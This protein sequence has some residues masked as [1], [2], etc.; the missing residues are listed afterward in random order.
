MKRILGLDLGTNSIG[1]A[2]IQQDFE[3]HEGIINDLGV[4]IIPMD[5]AELSDYESGN[6]ISKT[7]ERTRLRGARRIRERSLLRRERLHRVLNI[8]GYLPSHYKDSIDFEHHPGKFHE[9][10]EPK[11]AYCK[12]KANQFE[13]LFKDSFFEM[14]EDFKQYQPSLVE[15]GK[16]I[17]YDWTIYFLRKKA[18]VH[19]LSKEELA[20]VILNFNQKRGYYQLRGDE[21]EEDET[22]IVEYHSLKV[23]KVEADSAKKPTG[24]IWYNC[25]LENG[26]IYRRS[27]KEP[28]EWEGKIKEF[29]VTTEL[30]N[31]GVIKKDKDGNVK[32]S[33]RVPKEDDWTLVKKKTELDIENSGKTI[34]QYIYDCILLKPDQK[35][36]GKLIRTIERK[37]YRE[38]LRKIL[39]KQKEFHLEFN[40]KTILDECIDNLYPNNEAHARSLKQRNLQNLLIEDIIFYQRPLK[41]KKSDVANCKFEQY[42]Y[43]DQNGSEIIVPAKCIAKSHPLYQEFRLWKF[44]QS[45]RIYHR[46]VELNGKLIADLDITD[47]ILNSESA[48]CELFNWLNLK[49]S[50]SQKELLKFYQLKEESYR[51][52]YVED[53]IY[54]CNETKSL[55]ISRLDRC[56]ND[57]GNFLTP[58]IEMHLWHLLFSIND[59]Q[60]LRK[61]LGSFAVKHN[62]PDSFIKEFEK[63]PPF[64]NEYG[65]YSFKALRKILP[66]MKTGEYWSQDNFEQRTIERISKIVNG[67]FD[68]N[69]NTRVREKCINLKNLYDFKFIP[70][71]L[72]SYVV[73]NRFTEDGDNVK[74]NSPQDIRDY[75]K[76][77]FKQHSL[78]NPVVE[79]VVTETLRVVADLWDYHGN[80]APKYFDEIHIELG[81]D[82]KNPVALRQKMTNQISDNENTNLRLK[83]LLLELLNDSNYE[84]IRPNS[85]SQLD[86]LKIYEEGALSSAIEIND[87]IIKIS[88]NCTPTKSELIKYKLWLEQK[89]RSP[90]TG[91]IIPLSKLFTTA[92]QIEHIIPQARF[93]DDSFSN[94]VICEAEVN[95][96]KGKQLAF[97]YIVNNGGKIIQ[98]SYGKTVTILRTE[99][100]KDFIRQYY[101]SAITNQKKKKLLMEDIPDSFIQRQLNDTRYISKLVRNLLSR[102]VREENEIEAI[103]K[104]IVTVN[105]SITDRLKTDWGLKS[106][107]NEIVRPRFE[108]LNYLSGTDNYGRWINKDGKNVFQTNVPLI[109]Q[110]GFSKKRIDHRHH[111]LDA[112]VIA[113]ATRN[114]INYLNNTAAKSEV[115][116]FE[117]RSL[118]CNK[119]YSVDHEVYNWVFKKPWESIT[120]DVYNEL[121]SIIVSFKQN[122]RIINR[123]VN[124][125]VRWITENEVRKQLI[126]QT[127]GDNW[128]VRKPLHK[129]T[130]YGR[131]NLQMIK[132][133]SIAEALKNYKNITDNGLKAYIKT[134]VKEGISLQTIASD[135]KSQN[136]VY[137]D[138]DFKKV[139]IYYMDDDYVASRVKLDESF[140]SDTINAITDS[141]IR[142]ILQLHLDSY[143]EVQND[144]IIEHPELAFS[145]D[146]IDKLNTN[147]KEFNSGV[148]HKPIYKVRKFEPLG[149]KFQ[150]GYKGVNQKKFVEAAKGT[151][152]FFGIYKSNDG[153]RAYD[154]IPLNIVIERLKQGL[155]PVPETDDKGNVLEFY[156]SPNDLI[157]I[158]GAK[159]IYKVVSFT[160][161][162]LYAIPHYVANCI[163]NKYEYTLLNK[164]EKTDEGISIKEKAVKLQINRLGKVVSAYSFSKS[165]D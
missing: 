18:L 24:E 36:K 90:Y 112:L 87:E 95:Q 59:K 149:N 91:Q 151:N 58:D 30:D 47:S 82:L 102:I 33:F 132:T 123:T 85:P 10:T 110:K 127:N 143:N 69:I 136:Y 133:V 38:E 111:A 138:K 122:L 103:S 92:Y 6:T 156:L 108:R 54:P 162:R 116:R 109:I 157:Q 88:K 154:T 45:L 29:I 62:L 163:H 164:V 147:L 161:N 137:K 124:R 66:L 107:W 14:V 141:G 77:E 1:S 114:H 3:T 50:I 44:I 98:L 131:V 80:G 11:I 165:D 37:Y 115:R 39:E 99:E 152:L 150:V 57:S 19:K 51:W 40:D 60:E 32:R 74:W 25:Y 96:D 63:F 67:E 100:Y 61:A 142:S 159:I 94:K 27:S 64:E 13:F 65:S 7:S 97:E 42:K 155:S 139:N 106:V 144:K 118:L 55:L 121:E 56:I 41:S 43:K 12:N 105:G 31:N 15:S 21:I 81:R 49:K 16:L 79:Q 128:A 46:E 17:P 89:Y 9:G 120:L 76:Y 93:F 70:D 68:D 22:K 134:K 5:Q 28:L 130:V 140:N 75:L 78:R 104:N 113:C 53:K 126:K 146:G 83:A 160:S 148:E 117:L 23:I 86:I 73:Y 84:N 129:E 8:L 125:N 145:P 135:L 35:I 48:I 153:K 34:G 4:R 71:W 52:N 119:E 72:A 20:W 158:E 2:L 26:W 101:K